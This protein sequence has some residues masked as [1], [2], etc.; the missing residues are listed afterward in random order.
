MDGWMGM[1]VGV[2]DMDMG[3]GVAA[4]TMTS[5]GSLSKSTSSAVVL[6]GVESKQQNSL[7]SS[8]GL[9]VSEHGLSTGTTMEMELLV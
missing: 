1:G 4:A 3:M 2:V 8:L 7:P 9:H 6:Y 5:N